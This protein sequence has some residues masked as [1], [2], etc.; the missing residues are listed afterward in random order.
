[1]NKNS[2]ELIMKTST[3]YY[4]SLFLLLLSCS[5]ANK[6]TMHVKSVDIKRKEINFPPSDVL[7]LK[8][9]YLTSFNQ[10]GPLPE[11]IGYNYKEHAL[12]CIN[13]TSKQIT[14]IPLQPEGP[15][16]IVRPT[17][18]YYHSKDSIWLSDESQN[19]FS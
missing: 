18:I 1:M 4:I 5:Q 17:G 6:K 2:K 9:Y 11:L 8:S 15:Q 14:Q 16:A 19:V 7:Q 3:F 10:S 12:D 13:L